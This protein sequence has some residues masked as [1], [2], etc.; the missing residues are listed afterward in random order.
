MNQPAHDETGAQRDVARRA[1]L[2]G[3]AATVA[4]LVGVAGTASAQI[5]ET[6]VVAV[7]ERWRDENLAGFM[8][9]VGGEADGVRTREAANCG[10]Q[11]WPPDEILAYD[12]QLINRKVPE[13]PESNVEFHLP[14][15]VDVTPGA[16]FLVNQFGEC[17]NGYFGVSVERIGQADDE[18]GAGPVADVEQ[19]ERPNT[20][21]PGAGAIGPG[22][23]AVATLAGILGAG[24]LGRWRDD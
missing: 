20:A 8:I 4:G 7:P 22:F 13:T 6:A 15:E 12:A 9:H 10:Y 19:D 5:T 16:L 21:S 18:L 1:V 14:G 11:D 3:G 24:L 23:G 17:P 2:A